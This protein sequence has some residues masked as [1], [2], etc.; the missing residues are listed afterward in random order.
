MSVMQTVYLLL[1]IIA[2]LFAILGFI[3]LISF[4][5]LRIPNPLRLRIAWKMWDMAM[6]SLFPSRSVMMLRKEDGDYA[7]REASYDDK[8][9]GY[10][11]TNP[12]K[13]LSFFQSVG[14]I[15][16]QFGPVRILTGYDGFCAS[17]DFLAARISEEV[18]KARVH[19]NSTPVVDENGAPV[20]EFVSVPSRGIVDLRKIKYLA[21]FNVDPDRFYRVEEN[22]KASLRTLKRQDAVVQGLLIISAFVMGMIMTWFIMNNAGTGA[23]VSSV[24]PI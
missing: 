24:V 5:A 21:P 7:F 10:W 14:Q 17:F 1:N 19:K 3:T 18:Y 2:P 12:D 4:I 15:A 20:R 11:V 8:N 16:G 22:A 6:I 23:G 9:A 13:S